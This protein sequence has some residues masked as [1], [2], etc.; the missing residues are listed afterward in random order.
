V[1]RDAQGELLL[2]D[3]FS[4][5]AMEDPAH[6]LHRLG[7]DY[8]RNLS[9]ALSAS[10]IKP[11]REVST[12]DEVNSW[13]RGEG[14]GAQA[15]S[16]HDEAL[17]HARD[18][19]AFYDNEA[20]QATNH[21]ARENAAALA[22]D[23]RAEAARLEGG[24][25]AAPAAVEGYDLSA[26]PESRPWVASRVGSV[27]GGTADFM[28]SSVYAGDASATLRQA[29]FPLMMETRATAKGLVQGVPSAF[30][31]RLHA[32][33]VERLGKMPVAKEGLEMG[34]ALD[35]LTPNARLEFFPSKPAS[36]L[37][38]VGSSERLMEAQLDAVRVNVYEA[39]TGDLRAGGLTPKSAPE[40]FR[41]V[42]R[43][44]NVSSGRGELGV[45]TKPLAPVLNKVLGSPKLLKSRFQVLNPLEYARLPP[46]ARRIAL[47][48]AGRVAGTFAGIFGLAYLTAD[49]VGLDPRK[50]NFGIARYGNTSYDLTGGLAHKI[51]FI[52]NLVA[53]VGTTAKK[54]RKGDEIAYDETPAG[55]VTHFLRSQL[56][57]AASLVPDAALGETYDRKP[58]GWTEGTIKRV[59]PLF[60]QD[61]YDGFVEGGGTVGAVKALPG[62]VGVGVRTRDEEKTKKEWALAREASRIAVA[63][64]A[65]SVSVAAAPPAVRDE[66]TRLKL[67]IPQLPKNISTEGLTGDKVQLHSKNGEQ[68][69]GLSDADFEKLKATYA[70]EVLGLLDETI[71]NPDFDSFES[72]GDK[73]KYLDFL[74]KEHRKR[75][76][77]GARREARERQL[78]ELDKLE[79]L[80][81]KLEAR[82]RQPKPGERVKF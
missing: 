3:R 41:A 25:T 13:L 38:W 56:S 47:R 81:H 16:P 21:A 10:D 9:E 46:A 59:T 30:S 14:N 65:L 12:P 1:G 70:A 58:F 66:L 63:K 43:I 29:L 23:Y 4:S 22:D 82:G 71:T 53:S 35:T 69:A 2:K 11:G 72:D 75:F 50:S 37:P 32:Q 26:P 45:I 28:K 51:K 18:R 34:L 27:V 74:L 24:D 64:E 48:K 8:N 57:P 6:P 61:I 54:Y 40:E 55:V 44:V 77:T 42:A 49:E 17:A 39:L 52:F 67:L 60:A 73:R 31:E 19:A 76:L 78:N 20:A 62:F 80:Q 33:F 68:L 7:D 36:K 5:G 15:S 79:E